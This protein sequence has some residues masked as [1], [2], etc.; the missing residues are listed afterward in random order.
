M[1]KYAAGIL[2]A[3]LACLAG[4]QSL[5]DAYDTVTSTKVPV[6][7]IIVA[8]NGVDAAIT[9]ATGYVAFCTPNPA[10]AGCDDSFIRGELIP[11]V[12]KAQDARNAA[13]AFVAANP[14]ATFGPA[15]LINAINAANDALTATESE[16]GVTK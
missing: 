10:P 14:D 16:H 3:L 8:A 7:S 5:T 2:L 13:E 6:K 9:V 12:R 15:T 4:C 11:D 1:T